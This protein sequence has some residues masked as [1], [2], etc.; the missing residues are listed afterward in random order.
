MEEQESVVSL[1]DVITI[2]AVLLGPIIAVQLSQFLDR[3]RQKR[4]GKEWVFKTLM[5]TRAAT[6]SPSHVEALNMIDLEFYGNSKKDKKVV[7]AWKL[8]LDNLGDVSTPEDI[9]HAKRNDLFLDLLY[10]MAASLGYE[11]DKEHIKNTSYI[12][13]RHVDI[14]SEQHLIRKGVLGVLN[15]EMVV[16]MHITNLHDQK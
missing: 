14:E 8:Y 12:P 9:K 1:L 6:L 3:L 10:T 13:Q 4:A 2:G 16:P 11:F 15:G 7:A 5:R